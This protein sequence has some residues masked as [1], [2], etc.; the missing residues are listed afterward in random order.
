MKAFKY[1]LVQQINEDDFEKRLTFCNYVIQMQL[2]DPMWH[3]NI[4]FTDE[5]TFHLNEL[6]NRHNCY[7]YAQNNEH[8]IM[9][10]PL[11]SSAITL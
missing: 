8:K 1:R 11:K 3:H 7:Y 5:A 9:I 10:K 4:I 2:L 6:V